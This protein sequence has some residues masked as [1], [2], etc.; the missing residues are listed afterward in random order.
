MM[1]QVFWQIG[2]DTADDSLKVGKTFPLTSSLQDSLHFSSS[3]AILENSLVPI[4]MEYHT[5]L[6]IAAY[7]LHNINNIAYISFKSLFLIT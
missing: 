1:V 4:L 5:Y 7:I 6:S 3:F 2:N